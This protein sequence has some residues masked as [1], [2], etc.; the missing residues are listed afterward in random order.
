MS[1]VNADFDEIEKF[2][3]L[4]SRWW[5]PNGEFKPLH[6]INDARLN[7]IVDRSEPGAILEVGCGGG[8]LSESLAARGHRVTGI[9]MASKALGVARLHAAE[10]GVDVT[11]ELT[12]AE[13]Y[14][15][16]YGARFQT[17]ACLEMLEHV[18]NYPS[19]VQACADLTKP[20]GDLFFS[21]INR[22]AKAYALL[23]LGAEYAMNILPR[24]THEYSKFIR[25]SELC[26]ALTD[27]GLEVKDIS[28]LKYNPFNRKAS[29]TA[30]VSANYLVHA[31]K[32]NN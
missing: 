24:G 10:S 31:T 6:D 17:V 20:G 14:A 18:S 3:A 19:T 25:P 28:G 7:Y 26:H 4:A 11:Y 30:D 9:D 21:T 32:P 8:I 23:I 12:T 1:E 16:E 27:A 22:T 29:I 13:E 15:I 2:D 5:D